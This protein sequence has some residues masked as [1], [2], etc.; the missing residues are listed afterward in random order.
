MEV[1]LAYLKGSEVPEHPVGQAVDV[2]PVDHQQLQLPQAGQRFVCDFINAVEPEITKPENQ[3]TKP[4]IGIELG[5]QEKQQEACRMN[6]QY[7]QKNMTDPRFIR[8][9]CLGT[10]AGM[11]TRE[12]KVQW[13]S[14]A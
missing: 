1:Q 10:A 13:S 2:I 6:A 8:S 4:F 7:A 5:M 11:V 14:V 12:R 9:T 3:K